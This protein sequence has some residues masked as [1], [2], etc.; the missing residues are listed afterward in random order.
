MRKHRANPCRRT[1][2]AVAVALTAAAV[3]PCVGSAAPNGDAAS[4]ARLLSL[5]P[6]SA[7]IACVV[8]HLSNLAGKSLNV[9]DRLLPPEMRNGETAHALFEGAMSACGSDGA[10]TFSDFLVEKGFAPDTPLACF[11]DLSSPAKEAAEL[12]ETIRT[13][14]LGIVHRKRPPAAFAAIAEYSDA[15]SAA[16]SLHSL[17]DAWQIAC[18][19]V[20][21]QGKTEPDGLSWP[22][23][24]LGYCFAGGWIVVSNSPAFLRET[25]ARIESPATFGL[26]PEACPDL[27]SCDA[28]LATRPE[29]I[30]PATPNLAPLLGY[31]AHVLKHEAAEKAGIIEERDQAYRGNGLL[32]T[33]LTIAEDG[34]ALRSRLDTRNRPALAVHSGDIPPMRL[35]AV[36]SPENMFN[37]S[38]RIT[39]PLRRTVFDLFNLIPGFMRM[40]EVRIAQQAADCLLAS[41]IAVGIAVE[42]GKPALFG[43][44]RIAQGRDPR[45]FLKAPGTFPKT[46]G[47]SGETWTFDVAGITLHAT[48]RED[49]LVAA[50]RRDKCLELAEA[51]ARPGEP[52][53]PFPLNTGIN[54]ASILTFWSLDAPKAAHVLPLLVPELDNPG[55]QLLGRIGETVREVRGIKRSDKGW[56]EMTLSVY[57]K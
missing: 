11:F 49:I 42:D 10:K 3:F 20:S 41:E 40:R 21:A 37:A 52:V 17:A 26:S 2:S 34:I 30:M 56:Q 28:A 51:I 14:D 38:V 22:D 50:T 18:R 57:L 44:A 39:A 6:E 53:F 5:A 47:E 46:G 31:V 25:I 8:P 15:T 16:A 1:L 24:A 19:N 33:T 13:E 12:M 7:A 9:A 45:T 48:V 27:L 54:P 4:A 32:V 23:G 29:M 36:L 55:R 43:A 35:A